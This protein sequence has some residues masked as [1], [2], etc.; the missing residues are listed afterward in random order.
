MADCMLSAGGLV[1][2][3]ASAYLDESYYKSAPGVYCIGA[4]VFERD[5]H[6]ELDCQWRD[7]LAEYSL[8]HFHM[9]DCVHGAGVFK[10]LKGDSALRSEI[11][12]KF[13][14][15]LKAHAARSFFVTLDLEVAPQF[16][17]ASLHGVPGVEP[18]ALCAY[19]AMHRIAKWAQTQGDEVEVAS[20]FELGAAGRTQF[21]VIAGGLFNSDAVAARM[22]YAGHSYI[23]K[24][25]CAGIQCADI[26]A[27][28]GAKDRK[29][30]FEGRPRR[31]DLLSIAEAGLWSIHIDKANAGPLL[32]ALK[33]QEAEAADR[34]RRGLL[35]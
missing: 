19:V 29:N 24:N 20:F 3:V 18:H 30:N 26:L 4:C 6:N 28:L 33:Q 23:P 17:E 10:S 5:R 35:T 15:L 25:K 27:Y 11:Q 34:K 31:K 21:D 2:I 14:D 7:L 22:R 1:V 8:P 9:V 16:S 32:A 13:I 12:T